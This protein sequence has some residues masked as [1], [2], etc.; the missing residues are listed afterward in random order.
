[1]RVAEAAI[2]AGGEAIALAGHRH[3]D[4]ERFVVFLIDLRAGGNLENCLLY[5]SRCV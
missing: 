4:D 3:V 2:A 1:M 5:T